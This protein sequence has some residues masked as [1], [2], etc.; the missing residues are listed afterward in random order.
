MTNL[1]RENLGSYPN[2]FYEPIYIGYI[3]LKLLEKKVFE[4]KNVLK[5]MYIEK[6]LRQNS[7]LNT[8]DEN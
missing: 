4:F 2:S 1:E 3:Q 7:V 8:N 5:A 6:T